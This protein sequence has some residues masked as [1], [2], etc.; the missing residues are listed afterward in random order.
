MESPTFIKWYGAKKKIAVKE[1]QKKH[2][3]L[4]ASCDYPRILASAKEMVF[5]F[6]KPS[7]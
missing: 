5:I 2:A 7:F 4:L 1:M 6:P 3:E